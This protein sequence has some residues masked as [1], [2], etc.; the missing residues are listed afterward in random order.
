MVSLD[1]I[2]D[3]GTPLLSA[4]KPAILRPAAPPL[5]LLTQ[6]ASQISARPSLFGGA[7]VGT[8]SSILPLPFAS[9][10]LELMSINLVHR[11]VLHQSPSSIPFSNP[12][13]NP[14]EAAA[15]ASRGGRRR[16]SKAIVRV[17]REDA[18]KY[19]VYGGGHGV[20]GVVRSG[21]GGHSPS[22]SNGDNMLI[23]TSGAG[24]AFRS[25]GELQTVGVGLRFDARLTGLR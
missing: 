1:L 13:G 21:G 8:G 12:A 16:P 5:R 25:R 15:G 19:W 20:G 14:L 23:A 10:S 17:G 7:G 3:D 11:A 6:F 18:E 9:P 24:G 22:S 2:A 4:S